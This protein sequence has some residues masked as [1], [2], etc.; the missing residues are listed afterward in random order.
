MYKHHFFLKKE[1]NNRSS[2]AEHGVDW[3]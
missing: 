1:K 2:L 3:H